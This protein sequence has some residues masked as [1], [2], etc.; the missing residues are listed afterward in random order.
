MNTKNNQWI[1]ALLGIQINY[2]HGVHVIFPRSTR[3]F[4]LRVSAQTIGTT[5]FDSDIQ[6][7]PDRQ[8]EFT[9][10]QTYF[11]PWEVEILQ[12]GHRVW[13]QRLNLVGK[14][15][16][17]NLLSGAMGDMV[18]WMPACMKFIQYNHCRP[19]IMMKKEYIQIFESAYPEIPFISEEQFRFEDY[20]AVYP[21]GVWGY[22]DFIHNPTD[23]QKDNLIEHAGNILG[24]PVEQKP[25]VIAAAQKNCQAQYGKYVCIATRASKK[26]KQWNCPGAWEKV[27]DELKRRGYRVFCMDADNQAMP[28]NAE[29]FTGLLPLRERI[30]LLRGCQFF[31]GLTSGLSW[32]AWACEKPVIMIAGYTEPMLEFA[33]PYRLI[34]TDV[35]HG[36]FHRCDMRFNAF[37]KCLANNDY[38]CTKAINPEMVLQKVDEIEHQLMPQQNSVQK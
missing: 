28:P 18:A 3:K 16:C 30:D 22:G 31:I 6:C 35:C 21:I 13:L 19:T 37:D 32:I 24:V 11:I 15:V 26:M 29:D 38:I 7:Q 17:L 36:C 14:P 2:C 12:D 8:V 23:F 5:V 4:H 34:N 20:L 33:N 1:S 9:S 10:K 27:T 25:P